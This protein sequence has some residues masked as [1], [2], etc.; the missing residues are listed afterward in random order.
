MAVPS[1]V[2]VCRTACLSRTVRMSPA[3]RS[4]AVWRLAEA[5]ETPTDRASCV[6][7]VARVMA[8]RMAVLVAPRSFSTAW[9]SASPMAA[10]RHSSLMG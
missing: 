4:T 8:A 3:A 5:G 2:R 7:L 1:G 6:V 10:H 9:R